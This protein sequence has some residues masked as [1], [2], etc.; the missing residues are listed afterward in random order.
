VAWFPPYAPVG[1][2][3]A[4]RPLEEEVVGFP[5]VFERELAAMGGVTALAVAGRLAGAFFARDFFERLPVGFRYG[6]F[7]PLAR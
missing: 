1:R 4:H 3:S 5:V 6:F 7:V 2:S